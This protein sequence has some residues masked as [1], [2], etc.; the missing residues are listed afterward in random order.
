MMLAML[1]VMSAYGAFEV[2]LAKK[3]HILYK[4]TCT[5]PGF[6]GELYKCTCIFFALFAVFLRFLFGFDSQTD[7]VFCAEFMRF[8]SVG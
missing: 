8:H 6:C 2:R 1:A 7:S 3:T 4:Y 5:P